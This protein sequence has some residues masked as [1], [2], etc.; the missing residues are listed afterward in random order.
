MTNIN[1]KRFR[2]FMAAAVLVLSSGCSTLSDVQKSEGTG[3]RQQYNASFDNSWRA[4]RDALI[5][6][7]LDLASE[8]KKEGYMLAQNGLGAFSYG[9]NVGIFVRKI[10]E[11]VTSIEVVSKKVVATNIFAPDWTKDIFA[12]IDSKIER[13]K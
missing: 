12:K 8:N 10:S 2:F 1:I 3:I 4:S 13:A 5:E 9:E 6:L 7:K 11:A